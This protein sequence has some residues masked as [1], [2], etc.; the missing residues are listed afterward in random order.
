MTVFPRALRTLACC[1]A[2]VAVAAC[3][4]APT[5]P[6]SYVQVAEGRTWVAVAEPEG[7]PTAATWLP[8]VPAGSPVQGQVRELRDGAGKMRRSGRLE[9]AAAMEAQAA[10]L[11]AAS[12][13]TAPAD[14]LARSFTALESWT[15][16]ANQ[17][18]E[19]G[20][21]PELAGAVQAVEQL[22][23]AARAALERGDA[24]EAAVQLT[25]AA[26]Q[27]HE[28]SPPAV[29][30]R[31]VAAAEARIDAAANPTEGMKRARR[32]LRGAREGMS[33]G[34]YA[35]ALRRAV[36]A[37]QLLDAERPARG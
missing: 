2:L 9:Q 24:T 22:S 8:H 32:L 13:R 34:D 17:R 26:E 4:D 6:T 15:D 37:L 27:V 16:R 28:Q 18:M 23:A 7:I 21:Y 10:R 5:G 1:C 30:L 31:L 3:A 19:T 33:T 14:E 25:L 12:L 29:A 11:A 20:S 35:R 36:Y